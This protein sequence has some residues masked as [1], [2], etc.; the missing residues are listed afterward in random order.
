MINDRSKIN[1][2]GPML[3]AVNH[4][5]SFLDA[6]IL[7]VLFPQPVYS[8]ARGDVFVNKSIESI[9]RALK[10][11]PVYRVSEGVENLS[12]NYETFEDC[13]K[14]FHKNGTILIFSEGKCINEWHLRPLKK[15][16]ARLAIDSWES[17]IPLKVLPIGLNYSSFKKFGKNV[18]INIGT[19]IHRSDIDMDQPDGLRY[20]QFNNLLRAELQ[21]LVFEIPKDDLA[22]QKR[23]LSIRV[24][25]IKK[26]LLSVPSILGFIIHLPLYL[27]VKLFSKRIAAHNDHYDSV[28]V[29]LLLFSYPVYL[30]LFSLA[31]YFFTHSALAFLSILLFPFLAWAVVWVKRQV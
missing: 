15:G 26:L 2:Q 13:K 12:S 3:L 16:T 21:K 14:I 11:L 31:L 29:T 27:P 9:L 23:I 25:P 1:D 20:Q 5:N 10:I 8:L 4:P 22:A 24:S 17:N 28:L 19:T 6:V 7:D 18:F 30:I